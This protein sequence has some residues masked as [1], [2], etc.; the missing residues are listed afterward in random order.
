M[1]NRELGASWLAV[2]KFLRE[3]RHELTAAAAAEY[4]LV[5]R[6]AGTPLL[7]RP[8]WMPRA[9][10]ALRDVQL[11]FRPELGG[12]VPV[13]PDGYAQT[14]QALAPP[15]VFEDRAT[16][17]LLD[18]DLASPPATMAFGRGRYFDGINV[19]EAAAHEFAAARLSGSAGSRLSDPL[20]LRRRAV[21]LAISTL[22]V[23]LDRRTGEAAFLL[24]WRD[25]ALVGH[26]GG[27]YQVVPV[28]VFQPSADDAWEADFSLWY[29]IVREYAEELAGYDEVRGAVGPFAHR[30]TAALE[31][32][33][34]RAWCLGLGVD[35]LS[36]AADLLA[37]VVID[38]E[39]FT[40]LFGN[41]LSGNAE[42]RVLAPRAFTEAVVAQTVDGEPLQAAGAAALRLGWAHRDVLLGLTDPGV[43]GTTLPS[44]TTVAEECARMAASTAAGSSGVIN[45]RMRA[46][47]SRIKAV[48]FDGRPGS[49]LA[50]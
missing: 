32:G 9:P 50:Q 10:I 42:G 28:G 5:P 39:V 29:S 20:D 34:I 7:T 33:E 37:V 31:A 48:L 1:V 17:R 45:G 19:G 43:H 36:Y 23:R 25:P 47:V 2:R 3:H 16:Y 38:E 18:A 14:M 49:R 11:T 35:P 15:A 13:A 30:M 8:E 26:A 21:N 41:D 27:M 44:V 4:P 12:A 46:P 24:H 22:T 40:D 6:V